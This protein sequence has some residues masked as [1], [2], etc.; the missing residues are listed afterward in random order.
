LLRS[1]PSSGAG[2]HLS[3]ATLTSAGLALAGSTTA[4]P[5]LALRWVPLPASAVSSPPSPGGDD[6]R[7]RATLPVYLD[8]DRAEVLFECS[9]ALAEAEEDVEGFVKRAVALTA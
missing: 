8:E 7:R 9:L 1:Y 2:V 5:P 6:R 3:N 4:L